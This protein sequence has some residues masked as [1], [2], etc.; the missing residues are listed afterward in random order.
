MADS[1]RTVGELADKM[2]VS[3]RTLQYYDRK[4]LLKPSAYSEGGRRMYELHDVIRLEQILS[5]K[6]IGLSLDE[7]K[8]QL[9]E[10]NDGP[11][12]QKII[13]RQIRILE[14]QISCLQE[15]RATLEYVSQNTNEDMEVDFAQVADAIFSIRAV[16]KRDWLSLD[17]FDP[18]LKSHIEDRERSDKHFTRRLASQFDTISS[19][20]YE[21]VQAEADP[22]DGEGQAA[23]KAMWDMIQDFTDGDRNL[24]PQLMGFNQEKDNWPAEMRERQEAIDDFMGRALALYLEKQSIDPPDYR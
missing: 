21:L 1:M 10:Q 13:A 16:E 15:V 3:V 5:L 2:G 22:A 4:G 14:K 6:Y 18:D 20:M 8:E 23:A 12:I 24:L 7:I 17:E 19:L 11:D 9:S